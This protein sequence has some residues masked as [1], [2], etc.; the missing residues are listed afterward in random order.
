MMKEG[1][2]LGVSYPVLELAKNGILKAEGWERIG[3]IDGKVGLLKIFL[4]K[5]MWPAGLASSVKPV[6]SSLRVLPTF[7]RGGG[8]FRLPSFSRRNRTLV[9][10]R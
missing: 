9:F 3:L 8:S 5:M 4:H 2:E 7:P 10:C 1:S 6:Q